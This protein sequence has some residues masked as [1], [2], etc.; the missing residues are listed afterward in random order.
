MKILKLTQKQLDLL[1]SAAREG[2]ATHLDHLDCHSQKEYN[3]Y[4]K[5]IKKLE[6]KIQE[7]LL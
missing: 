3:S 1:L 7:R 5:K 2:I 4:T 6:I